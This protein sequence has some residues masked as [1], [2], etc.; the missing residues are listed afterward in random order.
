MNKYKKNNNQK[1]KK[2]KNSRRNWKMDV[3]DVKKN[4]CLVNCN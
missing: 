4:G 2:E 1:E 3:K